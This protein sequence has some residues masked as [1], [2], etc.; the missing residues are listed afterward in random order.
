MMFNIVTYL[1]DIWLLVD[2]SVERINL[3]IIFAFAI[4]QLYY[5]DGNVHFEPPYPAPTHALP[6]GT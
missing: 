5:I 2:M 1:K 6:M 4:P 3:S